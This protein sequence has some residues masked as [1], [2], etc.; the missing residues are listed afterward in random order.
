MKPVE[1]RNALSSKVCDSI[2]ELFNH[3][4]KTY[5]KKKEYSF[6]EVMM[7][8]VPELEAFQLKLVQTADLYVN[9]Y[10]KQHNIRIFPE[11]RKSVV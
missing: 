5:R 10:R 7:S 1:Y 8:G 3:G 6:K 11:D 9:L 2:I 4:D